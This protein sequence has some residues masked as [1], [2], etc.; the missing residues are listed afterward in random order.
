MSSKYKFTPD[1]IFRYYNTAIT[2][3]NSSQPL[4]IENKIDPMPNDASGYL[5]EN[6][7]SEL[8]KN[9]S[10][11]TDLSNLLQEV[12]NKPENRDYHAIY[13]QITLLITDE[14]ERNTCHKNLWHTRL[15][16]VCYTLM[17]VKDRLAANSSNFELGIFG[18]ETIK[19]D[20]DIGVS[21]V[22]NVSIT[23]PLGMVVKHFEDFFVEQN[24]TS[25]DLDVE[26]YADYFIKDGKP[27]IQTTETTYKQSLPYIVGGMVKNYAQ[28][29][30]D[31]GDMKSLSQ[32]KDTTLCDYRRKINLI[33][34][35]NLA[36]LCDGKQTSIQAIDSLIN[37]I[38]K[39]QLNPPSSGED[40][41][42]I[43][44]ADARPIFDKLFA[45]INGIMKNIKGL[46]S[47][48]VTTL[49]S[50]LKKD[51][52]LNSDIKKKTEEVKA[53]FE[54]DYNTARNTYYNKLDIVHK[55]Y[56]DNN[57]DNYDEL[58]EKI[59]EALI[60]R[61][62]S[63][64]SAATI[65]HVVYS[66]QATKKLSE[67]DRNVAL[68]PLKKLIGEFGYKMSILEQISF[69]SRFVIETNVRGNLIK[70][71][72]N[73]KNNAV[74]SIQDANQ[75]RDKK[76]N[77]K[78][79]ERLADAIKNYIELSNTGVNVPKVT[80]VGNG[81]NLRSKQTNVVPIQPYNLRSKGAVVG[82]KKRKTKKRLKKISKRKSEKKLKST[83]KKNRK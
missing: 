48:K 17:I 78:Y 36:A 5:V 22:N 39:F 53:Y 4:P 2:N 28:S 35:E 32:G 63:H 65:Y 72:A 27:F 64:Q 52:L 8:G 60:Y 73:L 40:I 43:G 74:R 20:V 83:K 18:S 71:T 37:N 67:A 62:E 31:I 59:C 44:N 26:M 55:I 24:Y 66:M 21:Y 58:N 23:A 82:G 69:L 38:T 41:D 75:N 76:K 57:K 54:M 34:N 70:N 68:A 80:P 16:H 51:V 6:F 49:L 10:N 13:N 46:D 30:I 19:S 29:Q 7:F 11:K 14:Q 77:K 42:I 81:Y 9:L 12:A 79:T 1:D 15:K 61:A 56:I 25:L 50:A 47:N 33:Q 45:N 3:Y